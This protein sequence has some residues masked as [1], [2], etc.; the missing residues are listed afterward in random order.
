MTVFFGIVIAVGVLWLLLE[1][2]AKAGSP[3]PSMYRSSGNGWILVIVG[4]IGAICVG[5][6]Q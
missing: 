1:A 2:G 5:Y 4:I 6:L 3:A